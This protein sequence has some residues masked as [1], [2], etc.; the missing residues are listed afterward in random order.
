MIMNWLDI[1]RKI[2]SNSSSQELIN[3][4]NKNSIIYL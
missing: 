2:F 3:L 4:K 1:L